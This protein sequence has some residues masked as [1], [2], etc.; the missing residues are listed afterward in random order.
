M[1]EHNQPSPHS[2]T[3]QEPHYKGLNTKNFERLFWAKMVELSENSSSKIE[4]RE[5]I[6]FVG[7]LVMVNHH[8]TCTHNDLFIE[9]EYEA[10]TIYIPLITNKVLFFSH[11][12]EAIGITSF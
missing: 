2:S 5:I 8:Q 11:F 6:E 9:Y 10:R 12:S 1:R 4:I 3:L 7:E